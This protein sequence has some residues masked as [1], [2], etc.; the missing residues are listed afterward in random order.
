MEQIG[1]AQLRIADV[2]SELLWRGELDDAFHCDS[3]LF[4]TLDGDLNTQPNEDKDIC[5]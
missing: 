1:H 3:G 2:A 5:H 4:V